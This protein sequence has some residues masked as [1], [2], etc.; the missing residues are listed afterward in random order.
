MFPHEIE[1]LLRWLPFS[2]ALCVALGWWLCERPVCRA[3]REL[4]MALAE[5]VRLER[6][7]R[8]RLEL[9]NLREGARREQA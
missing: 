9:L 2:H 5:G 6:E 4:R 3:L 7:C 1:T 8:E